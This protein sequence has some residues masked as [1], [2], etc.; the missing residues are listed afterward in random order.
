MKSIK[1]N[2][3]ELAALLKLPEFSSVMEM[4]FDY[5]GD[6][7][8]GAYDEALHENCSKKAA[9]QIRE[10]AEERASDEIYGKWHTAV[11]AAVDSLFE[12][13]A[14]M[15]VPHRAREKTPYEYEVLPA[16]GKSWEDAARE[17][18]KTIDGVGYAAVAPD[19]LKP[20]QTFVSKHL[21]W[22][23]MY[24]E[25]YGTSDADRIYNSNWR[26]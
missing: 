8:V 20:P 13:H 10:A 24:P 22:I 3:D 9:E 26:D 14:L 12:K 6:A 17:I 23:K 18:V 16:R 5:V 2:L 21:H 15:V 11:M 25:V 7:G 4:N 19:D 1:K